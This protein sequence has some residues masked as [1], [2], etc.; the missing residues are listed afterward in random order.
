MVNDLSMRDR[1]DVVLDQWA[2][3]RPDVDAS[4]MAV[5][6]RI[7]RAARLLEQRVAEVLEAEGVAA[8][9]FDL[10]ATLRR[11]GAPYRLTPG[12]LVGSAMVTS[13]AITARLDRLVAK[14]LVTREIDPANRRSVLVTLTPEGKRLVDRLLAVHV[15]NEDRLLEPLPPADREQ[16][17]GLLRRLLAGLGDVP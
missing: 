17:A 15:T 16:L 6:G 13:G 3:E 1:V 4:P 7:S 12:G 14:G 9:E 2:R 10:L 11:N 5:V 8:G